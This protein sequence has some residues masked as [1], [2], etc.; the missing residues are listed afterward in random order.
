MVSRRAKTSTGS[1]SGQLDFD[2]FFD[3]LD[4]IPVRPPLLLKRC[5]ENRK[6]RPGIRI[7]LLARSRFASTLTHMK[8]G[9]C[10]TAVF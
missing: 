1:E 5:A 10:F 2:D 9:A 4:A 8:A 3:L 7:F 6:N